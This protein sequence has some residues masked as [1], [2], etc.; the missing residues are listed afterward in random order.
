[1]QS[2]AVEIK[3]LP[4]S[5]RRTK[6]AVTSTQAGVDPVA[7]VSD[8]KGVRVQASLMKLGGSEKVTLFNLPKTARN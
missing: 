1:V 6:L 4:G 5:R 8:K 2:E 7:P 3:L